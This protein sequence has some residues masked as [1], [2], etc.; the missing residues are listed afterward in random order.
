[1]KPIT[2]FCLHFA[3]GN[4]YSYQELFELLPSWIHPETIEL[5]GRGGRIKDALSDDIFFLAKD[6]AHQIR[7]K[8]RTEYALFG[9]S[10]GAL[11]AYLVAS[12]SHK[13]DIKHPIGLIL[14]GHKGPS[15]PTQR[16]VPRHQ[17]S[18]AEIIKELKELGGT[19][20]GVLEN[21]EILEFYLPILKA[22]FKAL[23]NYRYDT[24]PPL[25]IPLYIGIGDQEKF[26]PEDIYAWQRESELP[27]TM[28][29]FT[30]T[31]FFIFEQKNKVADFIRRSI[32]AAK[33]IQ[34]T[35]D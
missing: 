9:H 34:K 30:G 15:I 11:L 3:G 7:R 27:I 10:M 23:E 35:H 24:K 26:L 32:L 21:E 2:L 28:E 20:A 25:S 22:D 19:P 1:M 31:H 8:T 16:L 13:L 18:S 14:T 33:E 6:I 4:K 29:K 12:D 5:P 17:Y